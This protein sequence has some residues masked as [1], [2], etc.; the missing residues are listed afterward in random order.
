LLLALK[1]I[2]R[3]TAEEF[4]ASALIFY[5]SSGNKNSKCRVGRNEVAPKMKWWVS[6]S[7][8]PPYIKR[9]YFFSCTKLLANQ[10]YPNRKNSNE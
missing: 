6:L 7:L 9:L 2:S 5:W 1:L 4:N 10:K 3:L 8:Y